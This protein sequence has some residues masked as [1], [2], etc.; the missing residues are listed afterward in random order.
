[1]DGDMHWGQ[2]LLWGSLLELSLLR[3]LLLPPFA[4]A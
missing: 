3:C 1:M 2:A 4:I